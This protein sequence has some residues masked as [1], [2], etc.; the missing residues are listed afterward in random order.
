MIRER[1]SR[2]PAERR[3]SSRLTEG[4]GG[5]APTSFPRLSGGGQAPARPERER[6]SPHRARKK[7]ADRVRPG[8]PRQDG[9]VSFENLCVGVCA[10]HTMIFHKKCTKKG[11]ITHRARRRVQARRDGHRK[12]GTPHTAVCA[13]LIPTPHFA[14]R[15]LPRAPAPSSSA[16]PALPPSPLGAL[17]WVACRMSA[18]SDEADSEGFAV[19]LASLRSMWQVA[20]LGQFYRTIGPHFLRR[21]DTPSSTNEL[22]ERLAAGVEETLVG[23]MLPLL[24]I[25]EDASSDTCW[26][27][28]AELIKDGTVDFPAATAGAADEGGAAAGPPT[29]FATLTPAD[30]GR[31]LYAIAEASLDILEKIDVADPA[32][33]RGE[34]L[35]TDAKGRVY[36]GL[37]DLSVPR[38]AA[39]KERGGSRRRRAA[40][41]PEGGREAEG[42]VVA[43]AA[44]AASARRRRPTS[45]VAASTSEEYRTLLGSLKKK[46]ARRTW[47]PWCGAA[48]EVE[49]EGAAEKEAKKR[50]SRPAARESRLEA[51]ELEA[52]A[53]AAA[54]R[55][56]YM[57][58][59]DVIKGVARCRRGRRGGRGRLRP[60]AAEDARRRPHPRRR[61]CRR[62]HRRGAEGSGRRRRGDQR[63][64]AA[65][66]EAARRAQKRLAAEAEAAR[67]Q[68]RG[69]GGARGAQR[70][71][72]EAREERARG[73]GRRARC[74]GGGGG[75]ARGEKE[76]SLQSGGEARRSGLRR[77]RLARQG[78]GRV[79]QQQ[80]Q[81][82]SPVV[83][84]A[85]AAAAAA[86]AT[87]IPTSTHSSSSGSS[88]SAAA[89]ATARAA[90]PR[91]VPTGGGGDGGGALFASVRTPRTLPP[92]RRHC[93]GP[94]AVG[95]RPPPAPPR[96]RYRPDRRLAAR[97]AAAK[98]WPWRA[99]GCRSA[100][101]SS[102]QA[103]A[104]PSWRRGHPPQLVRPPAHHRR[105]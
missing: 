13:I 83:R 45:W 80:R 79:A 23:M 104:R 12:S 27:A 65:R 68:A 10:C 58:Q 92:R 49:T 22:E 14:G 105:R 25:G 5:G 94:A 59:V 62:P 41:A 19:A 46:G 15:E 88:S 74:K 93:S 98:R 77:R 2:W 20:A 61:R 51:A 34:Q 47:R 56:H 18:A 7:K 28:L 53:K 71:E 89:A 30:R 95:A 90:I 33:M 50:S 44:P 84:A 29:S 67:A 75:G 11:A 37:G 36:W 40:A 42:A 78:G 91:D 72:A 39:A 103:R 85:A 81:L 99:A 17:R 86:A 101:W 31:L 63:A 21:E 8:G 43:G 69:G 82:P 3:R 97:S 66:A 100:P 55:A 6:R 9:A 16:S 35:G 1:V 54:E 4:G 32:K 52:A 57:R 96:W 24:G 48:A 70:A 102:R 87:P 73:G 38:G 64:A 60:I 26:A 76:R